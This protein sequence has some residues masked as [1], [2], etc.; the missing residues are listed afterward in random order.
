M[1]T[2]EN[3]AAYQPAEIEV[4]ARLLLRDQAIRVLPG[5][6]WSYHPERGEVVYPANLL[7]EWPAD[8]SLGALCHE[9]AEV[10]FSGPQAATVVPDFVERAAMQG[11]EPRAAALLLNAVNDLR[12]NQRY[13]ERF[14][15]SKRY[16]NA[17]Y[18]SA[19]PL[20]PLTDPAAPRA[21]NAL[22]HHA[23]LSAL[24]GRWASGL[25]VAAP[26]PDQ[27]VARAADSLWPAVARSID[28]ASLADLA[29][30]VLAEVLPE[31][32]AL[33]QRDRDDAR[34]SPLDDES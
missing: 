19:K 6:W 17:V 23:L 12:V 1:T 15:G 21:R 3:A 4:V 31:Y 10:L 11:C 7:A 26:P 30:I 27:R 5:A 32:T 28:A 14:P 16:L 18:Q 25:G 33:L 9:I 22:A 20:D 13:L 24:T 2:V 34:Q 29:R 8:R